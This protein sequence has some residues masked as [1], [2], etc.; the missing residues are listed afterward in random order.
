[1]APSRLHTRR[2]LIFFCL[3]ICRVTLSVT[4]TSPC[5]TYTWFAAQPDNFVLDS[6]T[7]ASDA[8]KASITFAST[9]L[10]GGVSYTFA[11]RVC[12]G[13]AE[14]NA[15]NCSATPTCITGTASFTPKNVPSLGTCSFSVLQFANAEPQLL[16]TCDDFTDVEEL[17]PLT[18]TLSVTLDGVGKSQWTSQQNPSFTSELPIFGNESF[19]VPAEVCIANKANVDVCV[20]GSINIPALSSSSLCAIAKRLGDDAAEAIANGDPALAS[21]LTLKGA[22]FTCSNVL[23]SDTDVS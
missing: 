4:P 14:V 8:N 6:T 10:A 17:L 18:Y 15:T 2:V 13:G 3:L 22:S 12:D 21:Q 5:Y 19:T 7:L 16:T 11:V 23:S 9:A 20:T 1:M